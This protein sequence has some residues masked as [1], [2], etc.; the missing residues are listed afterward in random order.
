MF[1]IKQDE[2]FYRKEFNK[3]VSF[4]F[5]TSSTRSACDFERAGERERMRESMLPE[6]VV[7]LTHF[8]SDVLLQ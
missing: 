7:V 5:S 2:H 6:L 3:N 4:A 8:H 1:G